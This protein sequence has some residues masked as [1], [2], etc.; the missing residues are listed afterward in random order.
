MLSGLWLSSIVKWICVNII[1]TA[2]VEW[3][4][5]FI[6]LIIMLGF[7]LTRCPYIFSILGF[8]SFLFV[9]IIPLYMSLVLSRIDDSIMNF[10]ASFIPDGSP[11][12]ILP[13]IPH[14]E[15]LS[16]VIRPVVLLLRPFINIS[17]GT[18][19]GIMIGSLCFSF[20]GY[21]LIVL[22]FLFI[23]EVFIVF[24]HWFIVE[25][26]LKFSVLH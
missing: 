2:K 23:Y 24:V 8:V 25:E 20:S 17:V 16:Y 22:I 9:L 26:I 5:G 3:W 15:I 21:L 12:W 19:L 7:I 4:Y 13:F 11:M 6:V 18:Y 14:I 1:K 10:F